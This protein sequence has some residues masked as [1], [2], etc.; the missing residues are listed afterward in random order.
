LIIGLEVRKSEDGNEQQQNIFLHSLKPMI[1]QWVAD[2]REFFKVLGQWCLQA[3]VWPWLIIFTAVLLGIS[4]AWITW[5][6]LQR[7]LVQPVNKQ[8]AADK[9]PWYHLDTGGFQE[10]CRLKLKIMPP[11]P[12]PFQCFVCPG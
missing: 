10:S 11:C 8:Q 7:R 1:I 9:I 3:H 12:S 4:S 5:H 2:S 6:V